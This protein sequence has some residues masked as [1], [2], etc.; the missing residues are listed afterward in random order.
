MCSVEYKVDIHIFEA[1]FFKVCSFAHS[2]ME[3][4]SSEMEAKY[5]CTGCGS[6]GGVTLTASSPVLFKAQ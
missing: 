2:R 3:I 6:S 1:T 5:S 4:P